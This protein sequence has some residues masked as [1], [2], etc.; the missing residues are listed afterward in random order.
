MELND[1]E[2][3]V[4]G[5]GIAWLDTGTS[6]SLQEAS[7]F[8]QSI[9]KRQSYKIGCPEEVALRMN[10]ISSLNFEKL[11]NDMPESEYKKYLCTVMD[12]IV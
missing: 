2:V 5:R 3:Q 8:I 11:I 7:S 1:L 6:D 10:F 4:L 9:E 12:E